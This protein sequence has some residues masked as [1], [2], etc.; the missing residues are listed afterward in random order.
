MGKS[1]TPKKAKDRVAKPLE[2]KRAALSSMTLSISAMKP[3]FFVTAIRLGWKGP[4]GADTQAYLYYA[5]LITALKVLYYWPRVD[6]VAPILCC[7]L[8]Y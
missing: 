8:A 1:L 4:V 7:T 6:V 2:A 3:L 5:E